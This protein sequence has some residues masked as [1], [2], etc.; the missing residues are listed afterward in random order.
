MKQKETNKTKRPIRW[1]YIWLVLAAAAVIITGFATKSLWTSDGQ[2]QIVSLNKEDTKNQDGNTAERKHH[3]PSTTA[4]VIQDNRSSKDGDSSTSEAPSPSQAEY[5]PENNAQ[6]VSTEPPHTPTPEPEYSEE[7]QPTPK[8]TPQP[9]PT[10]LPQNT[11]DPVP[12]PTPTP[13]PQPK[14]ACPGGKNEDLPCDTVLDTN[15][16]REIFSSYGEAAAKGQYYLD[17]VMYIGD[18]EITNYSVQEVYRND[19]TVAYYGLNLWSSGSL[20]Q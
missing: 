2:E 20:I 9:T 4:G 17:E 18:I 12:E 19:H 10:P 7:S 15:Y 8:P 5:P 11:P 3:F 16:Y 13:A 1:K 6:P 14:K